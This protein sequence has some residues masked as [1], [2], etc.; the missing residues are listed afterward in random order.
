VGVLLVFM[1][2]KHKYWTITLLLSTVIILGTAVPLYIRSLGQVI[3]E[4]GSF[5]PEPE[6]S[7]VTTPVSN[8]D[9]RQAAVDPSSPETEIINCTY[10]MHYWQEKPDAWPAQVSL[11]GQIYF[12]ETI[13]DLYLVEEPDT[14]TLLIQHVYTAFLNVLNGADMVAIETTLLNAQQW[15]EDN[16]VGSQL[17]EFNLRQGREMAQILVHYNNGE[18][19]PGACP[20]APLLPEPT[21]VPTAMIAKDIPE[22]IIRPENASPTAPPVTRQPVQAAAHAASPTNP[23]PP[24]PPTDPPPPSNPLPPPPTETQLPPPT[25]TP[26]PPPTDTPLPPPTDT[27][28]P[29]PTDTPLPIPTDT[30]PP[31]N[32]PNPPPP[33]PASPP[34]PTNQHP[35]GLELAN[36]YGVS[37]EE[38]MNWHDKGFGFGDIDH[39]Y[40]LSQETGTSA[41][42]IFEMRSSGMGWGQIRRALNP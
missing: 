27:P 23:P 20:D 35:K 7:P 12:K 3:P 36:K 15:L 9:L 26:L 1:F 16:P 24:P 29:P 42:E 22:E 31:T 19:G 33:Q 18:I 21:P 38:I 2:R 6:F 37:Y 13:R 5:I 39:A 17:S 30:P 10:P 14:H 34:E 4:T 28:L 8:P 32:T 25:D 11:S 40:G 41:K